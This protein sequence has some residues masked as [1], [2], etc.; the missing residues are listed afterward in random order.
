MGV[1]PTTDGAL[2]G[3]GDAP[4]ALQLIDYLGQLDNPEVIEVGTLRSDPDF[5]THHTAWAPHGRWTRVDREE[6]TDVDIADDAHTLA[7]FREDGPS[8]FGGAVLNDYMPE[9]F[10]AYV[11]CSV[12]EHLERPWV[13]MRTAAS[14]V[15]PGG[16]VYV[17]THQTFP[18]HGYP[19]DYFRFSTEALRVI[20]EDAGLE[21][22]HAGYL[23]RCQ[24]IPPPEVTRWN[25]APDVEAWLNVEALARKPLEA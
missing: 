13:A 14:V 23:Y 24:I 17:Q 16:L 20:M 2:I 6:G 18:I 1:A 4:G 10:D 19:S 11:A 25:T 5:P 3:E 9:M 21:V 8:A 12:F 7:T 22:L 15:N